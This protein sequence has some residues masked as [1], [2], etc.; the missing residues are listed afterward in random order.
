MKHLSPVFLLLLFLLA[1]CGTPLYVNVP[2]K[3]T[4]QSFFNNDSTTV[5]II[6]QFDA[7]RLDIGNK[8]K[9]AAI[10]AGAFI[11]IKSAGNRLEQLPHVKAINLADS[12][13]FKK[14]TASV[15]RLAQQYKADYVLALRSYDSGIAF[16]GVEN[17]TTMYDNYAIVN[18]LLFENN[19]VYYK[20]LSG[21]AHDGQT[22]TQYMTMVMTGL[23]E[24]A[25]GQNCAP[26]NNCAM[27]ASQNA[28]KDYFSYTIA[29][30]RPLYKEDFLQPAIDEI[31]AMNYRKAD[32]LLQPLLLDKDPG[33]AS[34]AAYALAIVYEAEGDIGG[35]IDMAQQALE[36]DDNNEFAAIIL[37]DLQYE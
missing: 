24:K 25:A 36:K 6:N 28:L 37:D 12:V 4:P 14:D 7:A 22:E 29:H 18:F 34:R 17:G 8:K 32:S 20:K 9:L 19:G 1:S 33:R 27:R 10:K 26:I 13:N 30:N 2:V 35:A 15:K 16:S 3:Y 5:V 11:A 23:Y 21:S 31:S